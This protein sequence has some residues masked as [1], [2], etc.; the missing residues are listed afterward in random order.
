VD[1]NLFELIGDDLN[2]LGNHLAER[3]N[4]KDALRQAK[5]FLSAIKALRGKPVLDQLRPP[6]PNFKTITFLSLGSD[7][8]RRVSQA[9]LADGEVD[10]RELE[11]AYTLVGPLANYFAGALDRYARFSNLE[12]D[13]VGDFLDTF[14]RDSD[15]FG[16]GPES[17]TA[18]LGAS[19][20]TI[21]SIL[22]HDTD[23]LDRYEHIIVTILTEIMRIGGL[24]AEEREAL[25]STR[26]FMRTM[27]SLADIH[28]N[29]PTVPQEKRNVGAS[30]FASQDAQPLGLNL[31]LPESQA[32]QDPESALREAMAELESLIGLPGVK[33]EVKRLMSFLKIQQE[34]RK[35]G[36]RESGQ[37]LHFVF[38]GNPGTGKTT[39]A[40]IVSKILCGFGLLKTTKVVECDR[41]TLVGGYLGQTAIKTDEVVASALDGV[42]FIDEAY[43]LSDAFGHDMYGQEAINT[44]LKRMEDHRDRLVVIAAGYPKPM[45]KFLR[46]NPGL[47]SRFTRFIRFED[48][49]V[50][51][52]CRIFEKFC[53]GA[54][55]SLTSFCRAYACLL[56]TLAYNQRDE[57]FG[58][59][60]FIRNVFEQ[61]IS[62]H[63]QRLA[64][65]PADQVTKQALI[66]LDAP[67]IPFDSTQGFDITHADLQEGRWEA[68]CPGCGKGSTG[69]VKYL[70][71]R[72]TCKCGQKFLF[73][74]W[75]LLPS[76]IKGVPSEF[77]TAPQVSDKRGEIEKKAD[78]APVAPT[79]QTPGA[80]NG[81]TAD[82]RRAGLLLE[83]GVRL[84]KKG[85]CDSAIKCFDTAISI[86]WPNSDP[87]KQPYFLCRA[88]AFELKGEEGPISSLAEYNEAALARK[89]GQYQRSI[90]CYDHAIELDP[91]FAWAPNNLAWLYATCIES[92]YRNGQKAIRYATTACEISTWHC[93]SFVDT[94]SA[95][96]AEANDFASAIS[97]AEQALAIAPPENHEQVQENIARF[98][99]RRPLR[100]ND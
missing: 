15:V 69:G 85:Q 54:E 30:P 95:A 74:W 46:T 68:E 98:R 13:Q 19:F 79:M 89:Q 80:A 10:V 17:E 35:H 31:D 12:F 91:A 92:R 61:A 29:Q 41:S 11:V 84:L 90:A 72:V 6:D 77:L 42:L 71:Q 52:L 47:E 27:R 70:G 78:P 22:D 2:Y 7:C 28:Q 5:Q 100:V 76:S 43:T 9:I 3:L 26:D 94:L 4:N 66:T 8:L 58:N 96:H 86:D 39:V 99:S 14:N 38:T 1:Q 62:R 20:S 55:Y 93:W 18:L 25:K 59:A 51:D 65:L 75:S 36:L 56:F 48:Y 21:V 64:E 50:S 88:K 60:R 32:Q 97:Y 57:R 67:D 33:D 23:A 63:S 24:N 45:E 81:W 16:G 44:L 82:P 34:R 37:T 40:R 83:E 49:Q 87:A 53:K 73:P